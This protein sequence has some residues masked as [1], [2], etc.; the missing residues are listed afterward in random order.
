MMP[1]RR[2][3]RA[4]DVYTKEFKR[5]VLPSLL[6]SAF[7]L[8][9]GTTP[10]PENLDLRAATEMGLMLLLNK[11]LLLVVLPDQEIPA[12]LIRAASGVVRVSGTDDDA[13]QALIAAALREMVGEGGD[14]SPEAPDR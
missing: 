8:S 1:N 10:D 13:D 3:D 2:A 11:P 6:S 12:A 7:M 14:G 9:I 5:D 4:W